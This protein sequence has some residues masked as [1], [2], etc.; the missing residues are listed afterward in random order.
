M[1]DRQFHKRLSQC[2][3]RAGSNLRHDVAATH[4][5]PDLNVIPV[6]RPYYSKPGCLDV[7]SV[8]KH[9]DARGIIGTDMMQVQGQANLAIQVDKVRML[10]ESSDGNGPW[11][12][13]PTTRKVVRRCQD[14][15]NQTYVHCRGPQPP[16]LQYHHRTMLGRHGWDVVGPGLVHASSRSWCVFGS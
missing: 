16:T 7:Y 11:A 4:T 6:E 15:P 14:I 13:Q 1:C 10:T 2:Q 8:H 5:E 12:D 9:Q 3:K